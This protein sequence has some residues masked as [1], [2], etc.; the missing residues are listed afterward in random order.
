M[1]VTGVG[2]AGLRPEAPAG[3]HAPGPPAGFAEALRQAQGGCGSRATPRRAWRRPDWP[4]M[5]V[6]RA[7]ARGSRQTLV[8]CDGAALVVAVPDRTVVTA[9]SAQ[10]M[11]DRV[12]TG[13]DSAVVVPRA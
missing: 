3:P 13:I 9:L 4:R 11:Q 6:G 10:R 5:A 7:P 8:R 12:F 2:G 1:S